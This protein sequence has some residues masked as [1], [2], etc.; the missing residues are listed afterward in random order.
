MAEARLLK[1]SL[2]ADVARGEYRELSRIRFAE[3]AR[4]WA[5]SYQGRT[6]RGIRPTTVEEYRATS[7]PVRSPSS[8]ACASLRSSPATSRPS[9]KS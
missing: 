3:Y 2:A 8:A 9:P 7:R 4:E 5:H 1:S 6:G